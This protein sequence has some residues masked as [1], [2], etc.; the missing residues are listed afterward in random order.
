MKVKIQLRNENLKI[1]DT[2]EYEFEEFCDLL[3]RKVRSTLYLFEGCL[4]EN[5]SIEFKDIRKTILDV[6]G[7]ISRLP[8][9]IKFSKEAL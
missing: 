7:E 6:A 5:S 4:N 9:D 2:K 1:V 8:I 3:S